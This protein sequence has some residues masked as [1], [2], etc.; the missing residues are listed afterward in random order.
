M[1]LKLLANFH[2]PCVQYQSSV[3]NTSCS[4]NSIVYWYEWYSKVHEL[5]SSVL[6]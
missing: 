6:C 4:S 5:V 2:E 1:M 3:G